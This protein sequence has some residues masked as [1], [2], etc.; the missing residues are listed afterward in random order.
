M[1]ETHIIEKWSTCIIMMN[2]KLS[3]CSSLTPQGIEEDEETVIA[4]ISRRF[5]ILSFQIK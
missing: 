2:L 5:S 1:N 4:R 3:V